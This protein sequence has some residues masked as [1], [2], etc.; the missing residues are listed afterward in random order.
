MKIHL[1]LIVFTLFSVS[2]YGDG[3]HSHHVL[4]RPDGSMWSW[5]ANDFGQLG[6]GNNAPSL[7]PVEIGSGNT[8]VEVARGQFHNLALDE[9]GRVWSWGANSDGQLG[10]GHTFDSES[11]TLVGGLN[12]I[13][14][15]GTGAYHSF[16]VSVS[17]NVYAWGRNKSGQLGDGTNTNS[18]T[19]ILISVDNIDMI[20]GG[21][22]HT[23]A[24][25]HSGNLHAWGSNGYGQ[26]GDGTQYG[27]NVPVQI[28]M[29]SDWEEIS[30]GHHNS[31]GLRTGDNVFVWGKN[32]DG[33]LGIGSTMSP[34]MPTSA[35]PDVN[36]ISSG[37]KHSLLNSFMYGVHT[38]GSNIFNQL[39]DGVEKTNA[40][41]TVPVTPG[42]NWSIIDAGEFHNI[43]ESGNGEV[44]SFGR[45]NSGQ[46]GV[47][48]KSETSPI[49]N[50]FGP[51]SRFK[52]EYSM[53]FDG[54]DDE[55]SFG[56]PNAF[57]ITASSSFTWSVWCLT[58]SSNNMSILGIMNSGA[59]K[60]VKIKM[61]N[62]IV[63]CQMNDGTQTHN[64]TSYRD[65]SDGLW[66]HVV[67]TRDH[68]LNGLD[69]ATK[70]YI[71]G[72]YVTSQ[73]GTPNTL[74]GDLF[75][76]PDTELYIGPR[77]N[78]T[79]FDGLIDE[80]SSWDVVL[81][82]SD[83]L[84]LYND[85]IPTDLKSYNYSANLTSWYTC[86]EGDEYP[87][88]KDHSGQG[89]DGVMIN[90][91]G[92][93]ITPT[94]PSF[95][96][97]AVMFDNTND[98]IELGNILNFER[99][100]AFSIS[101]W[102]NINNS[103]NSIIF[104]KAING[105]SRGYDFQYSPG[106]KFRFALKNDGSVSNSIRVDTTNTFTGLGWHHV[107]VTYDG[108]SL[109]SGVT[110][111]L[112]SNS[113]SLTIGSDNLSGTIVDSGNVNIGTRLSVPD[114]FDGSLDEISVWN[115]ELSPTEVAEIYS[116]NTHI[117]LKKSSMSSHLIG[118]WRMGDEDLYPTIKDHS[119]NAN[120][121]TMINNP[122][123]TNIGKAYL[124][125]DISSGPNGSQYPITY[126]D[127]MPDLTGAGNLTYKGNVIVLKYIPAGTFTMGNTT[128]GG[129]S[130]P[131]HIVNVT[132]GYYMGVFELTRRQY[133]N[134]MTANPFTPGY[135]NSDNTLPMENISFADIRGAS[136]DWPN[137]TNVEANS[138]MGNIS[139]KTGLKFDLPTEVQWEYACRAGTKTEWSFGNDL[140]GVSGNNYMWNS[141][142]TSGSTEAVG[143]KSPNPWG[144][145]DIHGNVWEACLDWY[146]VSYYSSSPSDDPFGPTSGSARA[147]RGGGFNVAP[148][149][150]RSAN[151]ISRSPT[152]RNNIYG[153]RI[154][155][156]P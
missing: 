75:D 31:M 43:L 73:S 17:G 82:A 30:A 66:H 113:E 95:N 71:D 7:I 122:Q 141:N 26:L 10:L 88:V 38:S 105:T 78:T 106:Q 33:E 25:S 28:G 107:L 42:K 61:N 104:S 18:S 89:N 148:S 40:L 9:F 13:D 145:Y 96:Q 69:S 8:W 1:Y 81:S 52:N 153:L 140:S 48:Y 151:R 147:S 67:Y 12:G 117:N 91:T 37:A 84:S 123:I 85:G 21:A 60:W 144:L 94:H 155:M 152:S 90:M 70:I 23:L 46:A 134:V 34:L 11:P 115:K 125:V 20:R 143:G 64:K 120:H 116:G 22:D 32:I 5:G 133:L 87:T 97:N 3:G 24:L 83:V 100:D 44:Y 62:G 99:F 86:G 39:G 80:V 35:G 98:Y 79:Y 41:N 58:N 4:V 63:S 154:L 156:N 121:G 146:D 65:I 114:P 68:T 126:T 124:L 110:I 72:Q 15:I 132:K 136:S 74:V 127:I 77:V 56:L 29:Y 76:D 128:Q 102:V 118:W 142:N 27:T 55:V 130:A 16:A 103:G 50:I 45:N 6:T 47:G 149:F 109:A 49:T 139:I 53:R 36:Q 129:S 57:K 150:S 111:Y 138:F 19:P 14:S 101:A 92:N 93:E 112:D 135:T 131:E 137:N 51:M 119:V 54:V 2:L 59:S 108:S